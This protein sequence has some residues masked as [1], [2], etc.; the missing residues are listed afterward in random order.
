MTT[1]IN[2]KEYDNYTK[3]E[4]LNYS[5]AKQLLTSPKG[6]VYPDNFLDDDD[7]KEKRGLFIGQAF[8]TLLLE[9]EEFNKRYYVTDVNL[10][11]KE[12]KEIKKGC[13]EMNFTIIKQKDFD[14]VNSMAKEIKSKPLFKILWDNKKATEVAYIREINIKGKSYKI[15][16]RLDLVT[17]TSHRCSDIKTIKKGT[18]ENNQWLKNAINDNYYQL[19]AVFYNLLLGY[20]NPQ[21]MR[22][23]LCFVENKPPFM[24]R[25]IEL[26]TDWFIDGYKKFLTALEYWEI[27][28]QQGIE[29][30]P[31]Y[32]LPDIILTM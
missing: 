19:Q 22:Y 9:P 13:D 21:D 12:G 6:L 24:T 28:K 29:N 16:G 32:D 18:I 5:F 23:I 27:Y 15:K 17:D 30:V 3:N 10:T 4:Y 7:A 31:G 25:L 14:L 11:T 2:P 26:S 8:H 20:D 1:E